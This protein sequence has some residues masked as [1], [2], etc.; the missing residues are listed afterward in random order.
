MRFYKATNLDGSS[1]GDEKAVWEIGKTVS[2]SNTNQRKK[3]WGS[4]KPLV[5]SAVSELGLTLSGYGVWPCRLFIVEGEP[6]STDSYWFRFQELTVVEELPAWNALGPNGE[7]AAVHIENCRRITP[8]QFGKLGDAVAAPCFAALYS[9]LGLNVGEEPDDVIE[10]QFYAAWDGA[11][12]NVKE[13]AKIAFSI[14]DA[15]IAD[16]LGAAHEAVREAAGKAARGPTLYAANDAVSKNLGCPSFEMLQSDSFKSA[17]VG[18]M[19]NST[20]AVVAKDLITDEQFKV[21]YGA[22]ERVMG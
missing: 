15:S 14:A 21:L 22:W 6:I 1:F 4:Q 10:A 18:A 12:E 3:L 11:H 13:S 5:L 20:M 7:A 2:L 16:A 17:A 9:A 8:E 19:S